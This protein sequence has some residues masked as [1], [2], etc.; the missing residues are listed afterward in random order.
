[1]LRSLFVARLLLPALITGNTL[2]LRA[3]GRWW[4]HSRLPAMLATLILLAL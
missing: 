1:L 4:R 2:I 3:I